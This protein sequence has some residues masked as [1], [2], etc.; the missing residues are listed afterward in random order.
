MPILVISNAVVPVL[1]RV[2]FCER[3]LPTATVPKCKPVG[4]RLAT[5][6]I[7]VADMLNCCGLPGALS[8]T[9]SVAEGVPTSWAKSDTTMVQLLLGARVLGHKLSRL[10]LS[11]FV[12]LPY[13]NDT[14]L[15][16]R[17][18]LPIFSSLTFLD[19]A[20]SR[21]TLPK[22]MLLGVRL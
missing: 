9:F 12:P 21:Y 5:G 19:F 6:F 15:M 2:T 13:V 16:V 18:A 20:P 22:L 14:L 10:K 17:G 11:L 4:L 8:A 3:L 7:T 1:V